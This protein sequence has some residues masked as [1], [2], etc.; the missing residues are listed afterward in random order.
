MLPDR[1]GIIIPAHNEEQE[2]LGCLEAID[3]SYGYLKAKDPTIGVR[4]YI[5]ADTCT[6]RT[7]DQAHQYCMRKHYAELLTTQAANV[8]KARDIGVRTFLSQAGAT[9]QASLSNTWIALTDADTRVPPHWIYTQLQHAAQGVD[10][11]VGTVEPRPETATPQLLR[12]WFDRHHLVEGHP[13]I[14]GANLAVRGSWYD[15]VGGFDPQPTGE[16]VALVKKLRQHGAMVLSTDTTRVAT[17]ARL[18][19]RATRG[20]S[21]YCQTLSEE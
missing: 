1:V 19:G 18:S 10:C 6:D 17:S 15:R 12:K 7:V 16:D 11:I 9:T 14:F 2:L 13:H 8:G 3:Q 4:V 5:V 20:F 21:A